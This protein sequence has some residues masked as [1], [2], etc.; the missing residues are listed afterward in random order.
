MPTEIL[1]EGSNQTIGGTIRDIINGVATPKDLSGLTVKI[2]A[3]IESDAAKVWSASL[4]N[5]VSDPG[6]YY[7]QLQ[8]GDLDNNGII[9]L[10]ALVESGGL[11]YP[12]EI[13]KLK[14]EPAVV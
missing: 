7:Y 9:K 5:Q 13:V 2:R 11:D 1:V 8:N 10:Q 14:V 3:Q 6:G 4:E 12:S